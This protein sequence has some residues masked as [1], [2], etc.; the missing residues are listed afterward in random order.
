MWGYIISFQEKKNFVFF[1]HT[2]IQLN[3]FLRHPFADA[4][5]VHKTQKNSR[6]MKQYSKLTLELLHYNFPPY[7]RL[8]LWTCYSEPVL[9]SDYTTIVSDNSVCTRKRSFFVQPQTI[10]VTMTP[11]T[12]KPLMRQPQIKLWKINILILSKSS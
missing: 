3:H 9:H 10:V 11:E 8:S 4:F 6:K 1:K 7:K 5:T 12:L 2:L